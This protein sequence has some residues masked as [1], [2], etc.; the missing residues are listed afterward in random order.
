MSSKDMSLIGVHSTM[1]SN[2]KYY[3]SSVFATLK[4]RLGLGNLG[5]RHDLVHERRELP[6]L[7]RRPDF[8]DQSRKDL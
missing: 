1:Q 3:L 8:A 7:E 6:C 2:G 4:D 5:N